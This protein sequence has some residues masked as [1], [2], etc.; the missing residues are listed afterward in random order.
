[1][2]DYVILN[3]NGDDHKFSLGEGFGQISASET[4]V[5][6]LRNR[7]GLPGEPT[8]EVGEKIGFAGTEVSCGEGFCGR[9]TVLANGK[10]TASCL[11]L[12]SECDGKQIVTFE[13]LQKQENGR[14]DPLVNAILDYT[15]FICRVCT[16]GIVVAAKSLFNRNPHP[17]ESEIRE[18][19]SGNFCRLE[20]TCGIKTQLVTH[21]AKYS[22]LR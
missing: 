6:T 15:G 8:P 22:A 3:I 1:M 18:G 16:P 14:P 13:G 12:T 21:L 7:L 19:L 2:K 9:C 11:T 10:A 5:E 4:L 20:K 17:T